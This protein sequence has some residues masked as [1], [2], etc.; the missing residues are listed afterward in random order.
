M[1]ASAMM[2]QAAMNIT[3]TNNAAGQ[4]DRAV[5]TGVAV[6]VETIGKAL[7]P[8]LTSTMFAWCLRHWG[9]DGHGAVFYVL[10]SWQ[11]LSLETAFG[12]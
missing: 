12:L 4:A 7:G 9:F 11:N 1:T 2:S 8:I 5:V 6:T 10:V 3:F